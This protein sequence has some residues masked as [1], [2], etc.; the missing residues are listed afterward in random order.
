MT[1][2]LLIDP[3][4]F[5]KGVKSMKLAVVAALFERLNPRSHIEILDLNFFSADE[6]P[7][8]L[9]KY[10]GFGLVGLS[11]SAQNFNV[12]VEVSGMIKAANADVTVIWG[13]EFPT[14]LPEKCLTAC[15]AVLCGDFADVCSDFWN[16]FRYN[17]LQ[18]IYKGQRSA[19]S[20]LNVH[21]RLDLLAPYSYWKFLGE[22]IELTKGCVHKCT[23]CMVHVMQKEQVTHPLSQIE[24]DLKKNPRSFLNVVDYNVMIDRE[25]LIKAA[26]LIEKSKSVK[27]WMCEMCIE[28]LE[29]TELVKQLAKSRLKIIYCGLESAEPS[30]LESVNKRQ[31]I[32]S[33]Y[34]TLIRKAQQHGIQIG[35]GL[36]IGL[37][38]SSME[39]IKQTLKMYNELGLI[40]MKVTFLTFNPGTKVNSSMKNVG[41]YITD[42]VTAFDGIHATY[43]FKDQKQDDLYQQ[44]E[45]AIKEFYSFSSA[46]YRSRHLKGKFRKRLFF[47]LFSYCYGLTY[48]KWLQFQILQ[49]GAGNFNKMLAEKFQKGFIAKMADNWVSRLA[50]LMLIFSLFAGE[51]VFAQ[52]P[53][54]ADTA[55]PHGD[56]IK[57]CVACHQEEYKA[58]KEGPHAQIHLIPSQ[59]DAIFKT[60]PLCLRCHNPQN[61]FDSEKL[62]DINAGNYHEKKFY[63]SLKADRSKDESTGTSCITCHVSGNKVM[64]SPQYKPDEK[65]LKELQKDP[66]F[67]NPVADA[68]VKYTCAACH[69]EYHHIDKNL[70][71]AIAK[72]DCD[73]CH[74]EKV[75]SDNVHSYY[76]S[77][78]YEF[79]SDNRLA[80]RI[81]AL[82]IFKS[83]KISVTGT[84]KRELQFSLL[85]DASPH[86]LFTTSPRGYL[87]LLKVPS[88]DGKLAEFKK[89]RFVSAEPGLEL[90]KE[91][92]DKIPG[93]YVSLGGYGSKVELKYALPDDVPKNGKVIAEIYFQRNSGFEDAIKINTLEYPF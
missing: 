76:W 84:D 42:D 9:K 91:I 38:K 52:M 20:V 44:A 43:L 3:P 16:D 24:T 78:D 6:W 55:K 47:I 79:P 36:I 64:A 8:L 51:P 54:W 61:V 49:T 69:S 33:T 12:A 67:C 75:G 73:T 34:E 48:K 23:F 37:G 82:T 18:K 87:V 10:S 45:F 59:R 2:I 63:K 88:K 68:R 15:D 32:V 57:S 71:P 31:N 86:P 66:N 25:H 46:W 5:P 77:R 11:V 81:K 39:S 70:S 26:A 27:G 40:Y 1:K 4:T 35:A 58:W 93:E 83:L 53:E 41:D 50:S 62:K 89:I 14:L 60:G 74:T 85:N 72:M 65:K 90:P 29:D 28:S 13:G 56:R 92:K 80:K 17:N 30:S 19:K 21:P 22:P 7:S